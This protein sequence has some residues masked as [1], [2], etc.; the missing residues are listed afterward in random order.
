LLV[1]AVAASCGNDGDDVPA[2]EAPM[3]IT[4]RSSA[5]ADGDSIPRR[6]TCDGDDVSPPLEW[7]GVP[8]STVELALLVEDPDAPGGTFAHWVLW[9]LDG[10]LSGLGEG[11]VPVHARA[12]RNDFGRAGWG[13]PCPP[14]GSD[15]HRYVF[16]LLALSDPLEVEAEA[17]ASD[18]KRAAEG[19]VLAEGRLTGS[20]G[21]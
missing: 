8:S 1:V 20:Y 2:P 15:P 4:L 13:G 14:R 19:K 17:S 16:T 10:G 7:S 12:G 3:T 11:D 9:G 5:F 21:R 18:V 6:F